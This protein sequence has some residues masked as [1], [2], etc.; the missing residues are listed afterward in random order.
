MAARLLRRSKPAFMFWQAPG[1]H[2]HGIVDVLSG[3]SLFLDATMRRSRFVLPALL[4]LAF[5][6]LPVAARTAPLASANGETSECPDVPAADADNDPAPANKAA[7]KRAGGAPATGKPRP[8]A[9]SG[10]PLQV[11]G[12]RWHRFL[13]GMFR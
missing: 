6:S 4:V 8:S 11:R 7:A 10:D 1:G 9:R 13:P 5:V 3:P 2:M 12:P